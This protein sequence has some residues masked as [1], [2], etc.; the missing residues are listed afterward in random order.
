MKST[1]I[2]GTGAPLAFA[3]NPCC[4]G[5]DDVNASDVL[6]LRGFIAFRIV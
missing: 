5:W 4:E 1:M 3:Q 6:P 2:V